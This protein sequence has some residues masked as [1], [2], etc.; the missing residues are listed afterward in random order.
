VTSVT[1]KP[2]AVLSVVLITAVYIMS[3]AGIFQGA[4]NCQYDV[5]VLATLDIRHFASSTAKDR[6]RCR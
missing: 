5:V 6:L 2:K 3:Y 1:R 4:L